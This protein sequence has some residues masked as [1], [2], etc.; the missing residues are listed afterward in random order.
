[1]IIHKRCKYSKLFVFEADIIFIP[2]SY[3]RKGIDPLPKFH[4][5]PS[6]LIEYQNFSYN[7]SSVNNGYTKNEQ[8][9]LY[10][11]NIEYVDVDLVNNQFTVLKH[12]PPYGFAT[13]SDYELFVETTFNAKYSAI[14]ETKYATL[15]NKKF[16]K[17]D[18]NSLI[19]A[20]HFTAKTEVSSI[21][22][23][24]DDKLVKVGEPKSL[25]IKNNV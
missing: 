11:K 2:S 23:F 10:V 17:A 15:K 22:E 18:R 16:V 5:R 25:T 6:R 1:M 13:A 7:P 8:L 24:Y 3:N 21:Q 20:D 12:R 4:I 9:S 14:L 19:N